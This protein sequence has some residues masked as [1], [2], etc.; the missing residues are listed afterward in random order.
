MRPFHSF[1]AWVWFPN[2]WRLKGKGSEIARPPS[3]GKQSNNGVHPADDFAGGHRTGDTAQLL[4]FLEHHHRG[5]AADVVG[6]GGLGMRFGIEL[7]QLRLG[8]QGIRG[9]LKR[10]CHRS[11]RAAPRCPEIHHHR[12]LTASH[13]LG[14]AARIQGDGLAGDQRLMAA[15]AVGLATQLIHRDA[16]GGVAMGTDDVQFFG[17]GGLTDRLATAR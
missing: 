13:V 4:A 11:A 6:R 10:R 9:L 16:V 1:K 2:R 17:H 3:I 8:F 7:H 15:A 12:E 14:K 5:N